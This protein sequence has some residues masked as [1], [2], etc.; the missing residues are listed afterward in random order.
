MA[1]RKKSHKTK[2]TSFKVSKKG[3]IKIVSVLLIAA[4]LAW[5]F[6]ITR[7]LPDQSPEVPSYAAPK[8]GNSTP[9]VILEAE[10]FSTYSLSGGLQIYDDSSASGGKGMMFSINTTANGSIAF[11]N[12]VSKI[13]VTAKSDRCHG[14]PTLVVKIGDTEVINRKVTASSWGDYSTNLEL[15][16]GSHN[17]SITFM[18]D[19]STTSGQGCDRT[20]FV[21]KI[22]FQ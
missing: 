8:S 19:Y 9:Q 21:D 7:L 10:N 15:S 4:V 22:S 16:P 18:N 17:I 6:V 3:V 1:A 2:P 14:G 5:F 12:N 11:E 13:T 20:L